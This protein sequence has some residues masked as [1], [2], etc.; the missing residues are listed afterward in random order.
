MN[1]R[2]KNLPAD[3]R[4]SVTVAT[5][6]DLAAEQDPSKITT[7]AIAHRMNLTQGALFRHFPTK[8]SVWQAAMEWVADRLLARIDEAAKS[9]QSPLSALEAMFLAHVD[10]VAKHPGVPRMLFGELQRA[11]ATPAKQL[12]QTLITQYGFRLHALIEQGKAQGELSTDV[13]PHA[14][15]TL[16]IGSI[17][18]LVMQSLLAGNVRRIRS[19][20]PGAFAIFSRGIR[21]V[22]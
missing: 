15:A 13:D 1:S 9:A 21:R 6:I 22:P 20:A 10:F 2:S 12:V 7:S 14:A 8:D 3:E 11:E 19:A 4:R 16:F 5:V 17:Q 18:G